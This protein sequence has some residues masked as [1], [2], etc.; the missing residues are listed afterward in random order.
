MLDRQLAASG[1]DIV[2]TRTVAGGGP[3]S[4]TCRAQVRSYQPHELVAG[5]GLIQGDSLVV[6]SPTQIAAAGWAG[7]Q[8]GGQPDVRIPDKNKGDK[9]VI[10]GRTR[11]V[12]MAWG[13]YLAGELVRIEMQVR[14]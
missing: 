12:Q 2:L 10:A 9:V 13:T 14:G 5:T 3:V 8:V 6:I 1:Q 11:A 7:P 4:V